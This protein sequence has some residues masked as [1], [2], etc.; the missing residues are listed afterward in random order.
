M[1]KEQIFG[2]NLKT[3]Y[4]KGHTTTHTKSKENLKDERK[5]KDGILHPK[6]QCISYSQL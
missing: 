2:I 5:S 3:H 4:I 6:H 1:R